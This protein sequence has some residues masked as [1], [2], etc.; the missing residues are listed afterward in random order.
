[1]AH[2]CFLYGHDAPKFRLRFESS[3]SRLW[4]PEGFQHTKYGELRRIR[5]T[6]WAG[7]VFFSLTGQPEYLAAET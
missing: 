7:L 5:P 1:M 6:D 3:S 4:I 2:A